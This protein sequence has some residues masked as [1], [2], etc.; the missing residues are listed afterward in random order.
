MP[1]FKIAQGPW[2]LLLKGTVKEREME[3][4]LNPQ[5]TLFV[6]L[7]QKENG[8]YTHATCEFYHPY[9]ATGDVNGFIQTLP[10]EILLLTK[11]S[12]GETSSFL[13]LGSTPISVVWEEGIVLEQTDILLKKLDMGA[14]LLQEVGKAYDITLKPMNENPPSIAE[15]FF[16][17]PLLYTSIT[18]NAHFV[19]NADQGVLAAATASGHM[20]AMPGEFVLGITGNNLVVKEPI[21][22]FKKTGI[23]NARAEHRKHILQ[24]IGEGA[25]FSNIPL[26]IVDWENEY[27]VMRSPNPNTQRLREQKIEGDPIGFPLKEFVPPE[28]LKI[29]LSQVHPEGLTEALGLSHTELGNRLIEFLREHH[30]SSVDEIHGILRQ[31]PPSQ[32]FNAFQMGSI[33]RIFTLLNQ[34]YPGLFNGINPTEEISKSWFQSIGRVGVLRLKNVAPKLQKILIHAVL[35]GIYEMYSRKGVSGRVKTFILIPEAGKL[36][37]DLHATIIGKEIERLLTLSV[38]QDVGFLVSSAQEADIPKGL[39]GILDAKLSVVAGREAAVTLAGRKN[40]RVN[41]R[42]TY[43]QPVI[44]DFFMS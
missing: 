15:A 38:N 2:T 20:G 3:I 22:F 4:Y 43:S 44:K 24:I 32:T 30:V 37:N 19:E 26:V 8:N 40:Y 17:M 10:R 9:Y 21:S 42:D 29:D 39:L 18:T 35:K 14:G 23:F 34:I 11:H 33:G 5:K 31:L 12:P 13:L 41:I 1:L 28:N 36:F 27:S 16:S 7:L 25:L 6:Q